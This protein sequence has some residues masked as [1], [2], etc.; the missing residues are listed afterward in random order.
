MIDDN[1]FAD[2]YKY[3]IEKSE[4]INLTNTPNNAKGYMRYYETE[5][6]IPEWTIW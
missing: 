1:F 2:I 3:D 4:L 5:Q 6:D